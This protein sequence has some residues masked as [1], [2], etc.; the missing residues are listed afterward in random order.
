MFNIAPVLL[1]LIFPLAFLQ[2][3]LYLHSARHSVGHVYSDPPYAIFGK[4]GWNMAGT[5]RPKG[6]Q[7]PYW[8][9]SSVRTG[10]LI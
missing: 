5:T 2:K 10:L 7:P 8:V 9:S 1:F 6:Q 4:E 3:L